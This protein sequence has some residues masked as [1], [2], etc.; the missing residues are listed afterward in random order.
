MNY[1]KTIITLVALAVAGVAAAA[2]TADEAKQ[3]GTTLTPWGAEKAGNK[4]GTIPEYTGGVKNPPKYDYKTGILRDP[5]P[6]D[7]PLFRIDAKN[8]DKYADKLT[9]GVQ[10]MLKKYPDMFVDVYP[11]RRSVSYPQDVLDNSAKNATRCSLSADGNTLDIS[12]GCRFGLPFPIPKTGPEAV[13]NLINAYWGPARLRQFS[14]LL[15]KPNG[16]IV[17]TSTVFNYEDNQLY[18]KAIPNPWLH[19]QMKS[20]YLAPTRNVGNANLIQDTLKNQER[21]AWAYSTASRRTRLAPD[22]A[23]DM[24]IATSGGS[25]TYDQINLFVGTLERF[26][27]KLVGKKEMYIPYNNYRLQDS[28]PKECTP[29]GGLLQ[30]NHFNSKC[31]RFELH[32]VWHVQATLKQGKHHIFSK[33]DFYLDEDSWQGGIAECNDLNGKPYIAQWTLLNPDYVKHAPLSSSVYPNFDLN[34][35]VYLHSAI[36]KA[37]ALDEPY[38]NFTADNVPSFVFTDPPNH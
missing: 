2:P 38:R 19:W 34:S 32:R 29:N 14:G 16:E 20:E 10:V 33:R 30:P 21:R 5:F 13:W 36:L 26:D 9:P 7:K 3:L 17:L 24:L 22:Y 28:P 27:W 8:M 1:S 12:K 4:E 23:A 6:D 25:Q 35:G 18:D 37:W 11:T 31:I 15:V